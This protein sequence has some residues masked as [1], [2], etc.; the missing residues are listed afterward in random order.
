MNEVADGQL[1]DEAIL[2]NFILGSLKGF[3]D[4]AQPFVSESIWTEALLDVSPLMGRGGKT[5][6]GREIYNKELPA[7][8][9][10]KAIFLHLMKSQ[11]PGSWKLI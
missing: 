7:G 5:I 9:Q 11:M 10:A 2:N 8:E 3:G 1:N 6:E 4:I